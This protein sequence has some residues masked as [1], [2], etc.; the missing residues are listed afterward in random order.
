[1][2]T[3]TQRVELSTLTI[4]KFF[5]VPIALWLAWFLRDIFALLFLVLIVVAALG[6]VIRFLENQGIPR[7]GAVALLYSF[8][9]LILIGLFSLI[10]PP[11]V[12][13]VR[14]FI[15]ELPTIVSRVTPL[16]QLLTQS[17]AQ[18]ALNSISNGLGNV[19]QGVFAA[20]I[21]VFGGVV[22]AVTVVVLSFYLLVD[23]KKTGE[24]L[25]MLVPR[26]YHRIVTDIILQT[27]DKLGSWLRGQLVL[28]LLIGS[29]S[30][31]GLLVLNVKF[32]LTLGV[33]AGM[34]EIIPFLGPVIAGL[35]AAFVAY[36]SGSWQLALVVLAFYTL[37]QQVENHVLVPKIM[38][39]A[40]GLSPVIVVIAL[41]IGAQL[42]GITGAILAVP[43]AA[44]ASVIIRDL[45]KLRIQRSS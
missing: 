37:L 11:L 39:S 17:N 20:T 30:F 21:R 2:T 31:I 33:L 40:V 12:E 7:A 38:E 3:P 28:S 23:A 1:M 26:Q 32:A 18:Q 4:A 16:Y 19:T 14:L 36:A 9:V 10:I 27:G 5:L 44:T 29:I 41:A 24:S 15:A 45:N 35:I 34:L 6:P 13:Q 42:G 25:I 22:S 43:M 8:G